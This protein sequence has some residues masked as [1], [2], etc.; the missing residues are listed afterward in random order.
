[1]LSW[2]LTGMLL[3]LLL[4]FPHGLSLAY[5]PHICG[6]CHYDVGNIIDHAIKAFVSPFTSVGS[7]LW[8]KSRVT[9]DF[10]LNQKRS[11]SMR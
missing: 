8:F 4:N 6:K 11:V 5:D 10:G 3:G 1:M 9:D 2:P 7:R